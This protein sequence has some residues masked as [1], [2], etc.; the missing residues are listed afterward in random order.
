MSEDK[1]KA[2]ETRF[3]GRKFRSRTEARWA[4]FWN[5]LALEYDY[6]KEGFDL[7]GSWYLPDFFLPSLDLWVEIKGEDPSAAEIDLAKRL[8]KASGKTVLIA[9]GAPRP[10][11]GQ[12][13]F[14][15]GGEVDE[16]YAFLADRR[17]D[18]EFWLAKPDFTDGFSIGP[19][20]GPDHDR[21]PLVTKQLSD[22]FSSASSA[23]FEHGEAG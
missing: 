23:R 4:V 3:D 2:I 10:E 14:I 16:G 15:K 1:L 6:E 22:A 7:S 20:F 18:G 12:I 11:A 19:V 17:N 21:Y 8:S 9:V 5:A 13:Y